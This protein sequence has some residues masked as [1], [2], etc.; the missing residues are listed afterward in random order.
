MPDTMKLSKKTASATLPGEMPA[1]W[2]PN[3]RETRQHFLD[4]WDH[5]GLV[6]RF[7]E[8]KARKPQAKVEDP[9]PARSGEQLFFD[10]GWRA[11]HERYRLS[12]NA[13]PG[14]S[15]PIANTSMGPGS[16]ATFLGAEPVGILETETVW[17]K[18]C[19]KDPEKHPPFRFDP[20][21]KWVKI[22]ES[23]IRECIKESRGNYLVGCTDLIEN[24][25]TLAALRDTEVLLFDFY[26]RPEWVKERLAQIN[27]V[28]FEAYDYLY[29][30][31]KAP[32]GSA[33]FCAFELWAPGKVA[34]VQCD[35]SS[36]LSPDMF[37]EFVVPCLKEQ[38][39]WLDYSM[40][41][42]DGTICQCHL[43]HLLAIE[44]LD[45]IEYQPE[46]GTPGGGD[47][48]YYSLYKR[49]L[50]A[51]K[52]VQAVLI[53]PDELIPLLD[54][55]G[56]KGMYVMVDAPTEDEAEQVVKIVEPYRS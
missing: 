10:P 9:G 14:D 21:A 39:N 32:D 40:F 42:L 41:H 49:I 1:I 38:C 43:D 2:K 4:W 7:H 46:S 24:V 33:A 25:D 45:A 29:N 3:W 50:D 34:K 53:K 44:S 28:W 52:S 8:V 48:I 27:Q 54:A 16:L 13:F 51:G 30:I 31:F 22:H 37:L 11:R 36:M 47:P 56:P 18:P 23:M 6:L 15:F 26:D 19:I 20:A 17:Y 12:L 5:E 55:V 35:A